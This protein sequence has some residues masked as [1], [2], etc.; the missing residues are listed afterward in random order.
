MR[1]ERDAGGSVGLDG[2][3][4][5]PYLSSRTKR[6]P[7]LGMDKFTEGCVTTV[8]R[9][10]TVNMRNRRL[11]GSFGILDIG[12]DGGAWARSSRVWP[13]PVKKDIAYSLLNVW[14][15]GQCLK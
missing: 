1:L 12:G 9:T 10:P 5:V 6:G 4:C 11:R 3:P 15:I 13:R 2:A 14:A 7:G 8:L